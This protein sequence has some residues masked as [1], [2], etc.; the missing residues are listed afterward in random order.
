M[1]SN[2]Q[3]KVEKKEVVEEVSLKKQIS[4]LYRLMAIK[5]VKG[6]EQRVELLRKEAAELGIKM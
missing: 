3:Q 2:N 1:N 6:D 5:K 4:F